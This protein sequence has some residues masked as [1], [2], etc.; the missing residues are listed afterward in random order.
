MD[1]KLTNYK[2]TG[3]KFDR[4]LKTPVKGGQVISI[5]MKVGIKIK[6]V[7]KIKNDTAKI[8]SDF[9]FDMKGFAQFIIET[10]ATIMSEKIDTIIS[11]W[12]DDKKKQL[13]KEVHFHYANTLFYFVMPLIISVAEKARI[14]V[15]L[16]P[17]QDDPKSEN[18]EKSVEKEKISSIRKKP[19][20][21]KE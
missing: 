3:F 14:P 11:Y 7:V 2:I 9:H 18:K 8:I 6:E 19:F 1:I 4:L 12:N 20:K 13:P 5:E 17:L 21:E 16:P 10:Q 15:P